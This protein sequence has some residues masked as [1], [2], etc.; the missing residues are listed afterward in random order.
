MLTHNSN[1]G[2][3]Q[4]VVFKSAKLDS[5]G[6]PS[7]DEYEDIFYKDVVDENGRHVFKRVHAP[8]NIK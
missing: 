7:S 2:Q 3:G 6:Y 8:K 5:N 4:V 1:T